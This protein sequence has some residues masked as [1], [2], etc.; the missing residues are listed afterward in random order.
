MTPHPAHGSAHRALRP[1]GRRLAAG[2]AV[3]AML[4]GVAAVP[5]AAT[6]QPRA[7]STALRASTKAVIS[8]SPK[9]T[10]QI[11]GP[12]SAW[13]A[14]VTKAPVNRDSAAMVTDLGRQVHDHYGGVA[15]F[16]V[17]K[18]GTGMA[19]VSKSQRRV[20]V[21][22]DD[23]QHKG[24]TPSELYKGSK[25][26][27]GVPIPDSAVPA[28]GSDASL[29]VWSPDT[30][31]LWDF[32]KAARKSDGWHACWGGRIDHL[33]KNPGY[34]PDGFGASASGLAAGGTIRIDEVRNGLIPHAV[35]L[36]IRDYAGWKSVSW[37]AQRSDG[38]SSS[39]S[40]IMVGTRFRLPKSVDVNRLGLTPIGKLVARAAQDYGFIVT[41]RSGAVAVT[42]E[43]GAPIAA[44]TGR[45]PWLD[46]M[47]GTPSYAVMKN[48]PWDKLQA[49]PKD[50]GKP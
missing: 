10:P 45:D 31:Q 5:A 36:A 15:A 25:Q 11:F 23:C 34:F 49:L 28:A 13:R 32:W 21:H 19:T 7:A 26:F 27:V 42:T 12:T 2:L 35:S 41:D 37:P 29:T 9:W 24:Y 20:T 43:S 30:D 8:T 40:R 1:T 39:H 4:F 48:F 16:N 3:P 50:Y 17:W 18:Y 44:R 46:L 14:D 47:G 38:S 6:T 33:S 22:F